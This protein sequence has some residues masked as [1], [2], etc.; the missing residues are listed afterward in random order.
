MHTEKKLS[1]ELKFKGNILTVYSDKVELE[2]GRQSSRDVVRHKGAVCIAP[3][4]DDGDLIFVRQYRYPVGRELLELPAGKL[5][6]EGE[7]P[8]EC[9]HRE[10]EE[11]TGFK[12]KNMTYLGS[13]LPSPGYCDEKIELYVATGLY[14]GTQNPD[15]DEF[16]DIVRIPI[17]KAEELVCDNSI[18]D[19]KTQLLILKT[20]KYLEKK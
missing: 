7:P 9:A 2:N 12:A 4:T 18:D 1:S 11:E 8:L 20:I 5:D 15:E 10:L 14:S 17:Q 6:S 13:F 19:G 3:V 16:L